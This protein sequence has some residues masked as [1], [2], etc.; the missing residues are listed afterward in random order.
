M[1]FRQKVGNGRNGMRA[2][3]AE[4]FVE[5]GFGSLQVTARAIA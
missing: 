2:L 3:S 5:Y 4:D 1:L